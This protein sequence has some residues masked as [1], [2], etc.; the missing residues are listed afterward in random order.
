MK[1]QNPFKKRFKQWMENHNPPLSQPVCLHNR[2]LY[3]LPSRFGIMYSLLLLVIFLA[4][5]NYQNSLSF[6]LSFLL[7]S[8]GIIS[9]WQT[10]KNMLNLEIDLNKSDAVFLGEWIDLE[11][12]ISN[13]HNFHHYSI[14]VQYQ[15]AS[16]VYCTIKPQSKQLINLRLLS[17]QRGEFSLD[18]I[19]FFTRF[20]TGLFHCWSWLRFTQTITIYPKPIHVS[21]NTYNSEASDDGSSQLKT[22]DGDDFA[23]LRDYKDGESLKHISWKALAQG[24]GKLTKTFQGHA[25]PSLWFDWYK[26]N[27]ESV[28]EKISKLTSLI[29]KADALNQTY[30][31]KIP[32]QTIEKNQG[33]SH[34]KLCLHALAYFKQTEV[35]LFHAKV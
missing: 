10:H 17:S 23:G 2:R 9:L 22:I 26:I 21:L 11:F 6:A 31:L 4:A 33:A 27:A 28:E 1:F 14:G 7:T 34:K 5:I 18:G 32:Q 29:L 20:P 24:R 12:S 13:P 25:Q 15:Q 8:I 30:G 16:P 3:I 35:G 19:T